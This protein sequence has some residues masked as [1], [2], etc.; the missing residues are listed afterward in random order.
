MATASN[1]VHPQLIK[2]K[3]HSHWVQLVRQWT[4]LKNSKQDGKVLDSI[5]EL[6]EEQIWYDQGV[7]RIILK[8]NDIY[9][10]DELNEKLE[11]F[12]KNW[13]T[14]ETTRN[15]PTVVYHRFRLELQ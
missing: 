7:D 12:E 10:K 14:Q 5:L 8:L 3:S 6:N 13:V 9:K 11:D 4:D 15:Q 1:K 2:C